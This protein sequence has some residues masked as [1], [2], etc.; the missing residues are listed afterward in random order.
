MYGIGEMHPIQP[1]PILQ[2][3]ALK[4]AR[5]IQQHQA[6]LENNKEDGIDRL[7]IFYGG[8]SVTSTAMY[9]QGQ[10]AVYDLATDIG[11]HDD[12]AHI[13]DSVLLGVRYQLQAQHGPET[14]MHMK[15]PRSIVGA[16]HESILKTD[17]RNDSTQHNLSSMLCLARILESRGN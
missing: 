16:F 7:G 9:T 5:V 4:T 15:D 13:L 17:M 14:A 8:L 11:A 1:D 12:A 6:S 10:C 2:Q 3:Y